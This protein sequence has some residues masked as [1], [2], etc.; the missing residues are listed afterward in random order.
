[1]VVAGGN[2]ADDPKVLTMILVGA[3]LML[4]ILMPLAGELGKRAKASGAGL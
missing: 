1:M 4:V 3:L 2:F